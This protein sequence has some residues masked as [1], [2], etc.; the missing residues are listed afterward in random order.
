MSR[1]LLLAALA[2]GFA[3]AS[4]VDNT[5]LSGITLTNGISSLSDSSAL[6]SGPNT[7]VGESFLT[8]NDISSF[9][10]N[11]GAA[12]GSALQGSFA[13]S[14]N[15]ASNGLFIVGFGGN[16]AT[17]NGSFTI[18]LA[19]A[20]GLTS[21]RTY[22]DADYVI[23]SQGVGTLDVYWDNG[24]VTLD[25]TGLSGFKYAYLYVPFSDFG[26]SRASVL[27]VRLSDFT[28]QN[29][30]VSFIGAGYSGAPPIPEPS[31]YGL[32]LGGLALAGAAMRR[33]KKA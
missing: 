1:H 4:A 22:G 25:N 14:L 33:K 19:L 31:T 10:L 9:T 20:G 28:P 17:F 2:L 30:E 3:T 13:G 26:V 16:T 29:P 12:S 23:T 18:Q 6:F 15:G 11:I 5:Q 21:G 27:G 7:S 24:S 8:D 32:I